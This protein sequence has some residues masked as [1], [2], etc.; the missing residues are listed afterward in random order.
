MTI[1]KFFI[2]GNCRF[3]NKC[4]Y[5]HPSGANGA[6]RHLN[7][8]N[9]GENNSQGGSGGFQTN[10]R[11]GNQQQQQQNKYKWTAPHLSFGNSSASQQQQQ[12]QQQQLLPPQEIISGLSR[13]IR[14]WESSKMWLLSCVSFEKSGPSIP[15]MT[16]MSPEELRFEAYEAQKN[17]N[18]Q[19]YVLKVQ[20]MH[21]DYSAKRQELKSPS[22]QLRDKL[23]EFIETS[24][25]QQAITSGNSSSRF[26]G[27]G[28]S[29]FGSS[30]VLGQGSFAAETISFFLFSPPS[31]FF[32]FLLSL[33]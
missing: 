24:R 21:N 28:G 9:F 13:E 29:A 33:S 23:I 8:S 7:F 17:E 6:Q 4:W 20:Q 3:G 19:D 32:L 26:S 2:Q 14:T 10:A 12:Q 22:N 30:S 16:D 27:S 5:E 31:S 18:F 1:C 25:K 15:G 11:Q